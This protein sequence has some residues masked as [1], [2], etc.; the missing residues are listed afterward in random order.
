MKPVPGAMGFHTFPIGD[1]IPMKYNEYGFRV[2][3][4]EPFGVDYSKGVDLLFL[5]CSFTYGDA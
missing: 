2:P 3:V 4:S 1:D 5:G